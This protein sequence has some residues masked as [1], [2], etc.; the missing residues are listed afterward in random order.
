M[1]VKSKNFTEYLN[2]DF[3]QTNMYIKTRSMKIL[4]VKI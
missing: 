2:R 4:R 1:Y 3:N